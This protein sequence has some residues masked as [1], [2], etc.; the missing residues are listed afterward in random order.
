MGRRYRYKK[1]S[2]DWVPIRTGYPTVGGGGSSPGGEDGWLGWSDS[3]T[4][5]TTI[6]DTAIVNTFRGTNMGLWDSTIRTAALANVHSGDYTMA[7]GE[8]LSTGRVTGN[9]IMAA[10]S[11]AKHMRVDGE[12]RGTNTGTAPE[13][14]Y[15]DIGNE[16]GP[17]ASGKSTLGFR[18]RVNLRRCNIFGKRDGGH[19]YSSTKLHNCWVHDMCIEQDTSQSDNRTHNDCVQA[20]SVANLSNAEIYG[21]LFFGWGFVREQGVTET[22]TRD[23][24]PH[25]GDSF[26]PELG[27]IHGSGDSTSTDPMRLNGW[28]NAGI[29][30]NTDATGSGLKI[31]YNV[32]RGFFGFPINMSNTP[33]SGVD[34]RYNRY[35]SSKEQ[36][37]NR[38]LIA[39]SGREQLATNID[40][41][42]LF[43]NELLSGSVA[44]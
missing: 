9:L 24:G 36:Q 23:S 32:F 19:L 35:A 3:W 25:W 30:L 14:W 21:C 15:C 10:G 29:Q 8:Q 6:T 27:Y 34:A 2:Q 17:A 44:A 37:Y 12:I 39:V 11:V 38:R 33:I 4:A 28:C 42:D 7:P 26:D 22:C 18:F 20:T 41:R 16:T 1:S 31:Y 5:P 40:N 13:A 43:T